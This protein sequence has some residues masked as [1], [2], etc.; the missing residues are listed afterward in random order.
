VDTRGAIP[1]NCVPCALK[2]SAAARHSG[3]LH[4]PHYKQQKNLHKKKVLISVQSFFWFCFWSEECEG[5]PSGTRRHSAKALSRRAPQSTGHTACGDC[6]S[7]VH[8][9]ECV[10]KLKLQKLRVCTPSAAAVVRARS[11]TRYRH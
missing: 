11:P 7:R 8:K 5:D 1:V 3:H 6:T 4:I 9:R 10:C 2:R